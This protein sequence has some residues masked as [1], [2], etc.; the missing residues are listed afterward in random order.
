MQQWQEFVQAALAHPLSTTVLVGV[1]LVTLIGTRAALHRT[2]LGKRL[3]GGITL[4]SV[5]LL[6][7][8]LAVATQGEQSGGIDMWL[9]AVAITAVAISVE[10]VALVL[11]VDLYLRARGRAV[12]AI[13]RDLAGLLIYFLIVLIVLRLTL[14]INLASLV[15]T[16]A[17]IT[18]I[19][20]LALQDVLGSI[21]SGLVLELEAPIEMGDW[22][23]VGGHEG[24]VVETGWR[25]TRLRTRKNEFVIFPNT[26]LAREAVINYSRPDPL[27]RDSFVFEATNEMPPN[28][29]KSA[30]L[31]VLRAD[32]GVLARPEPEV[33]TA[34][35]KS[36]GIEYEVRYWL[37]DYGDLT[38]LRDRVMTN[39]WYGLRRGA[40]AI[41][42]SPTELYLHPAMP[43]PPFEHADI[44]AA[45]GGVPL[46]APLAA[47]ELNDLAQAARRLPFAAGESVVREGEEGDS[48]YLI[49]RGAVRVSIGRGTTER[50][51]AAMGPGDYF[52][53]MSLLAGD[54]RS[55][56]VTAATDTVVLEVGRGAFEKIV[57]ADPAL[58]EP[59]SQI[60]SHRSAGTQAERAAAAALP[61]FAADD[62]AQNLLKRVRK[63]FGL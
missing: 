48:I 51:V 29:V 42:T 59:I 39:V 18:A 15:A 55:A 27:H 38:S 63:F 21:V 5:G 58:L 10:R 30:V 44:A 19:I 46:L 52:G 22:V 16:S 60:A 33:Y 56:T 35:Y 49:E 61:P 28:A 40:I 14:D 32:R 53:E 20:G 13:F 2:R 57:A 6:A 31:A 25:T 26:A 47:D 62:A 37:D 4:F 41:A 24:V 23:R 11:F 7:A 43:R 54:W 36:S 9:R 3:D 8:Y 45:L 1:A 17:V 12:S 34:Q 50:T